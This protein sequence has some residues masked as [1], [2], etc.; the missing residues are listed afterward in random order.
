MKK[1]ILI[2]LVIALLVGSCGQKAKQQTAETV[3][4]SDIRPGEK[5]QFGKVYT[6]VFEYAGCD[7]AND[8]IYKFKKDNREFRIIS[9][10]ILETLFILIGDE[11]EVQWKMDNVW[12]GEETTGIRESAVSIKKIRD[13]K[14]NFNPVHLEY[15]QSINGYKV[16]ALFTPEDIIGDN[17]I[18]GKAILTFTG[19][20]KWNKFSITHNYFA[21]SWLNFLDYFESEHKFEAIADAGK[22]NSFARGQSYQL[23]YD[24]P[25]DESDTYIMLYEEL[26]FF[27][28]DVTLSGMQ[29]YLILTNYRQGQRG[30]SSFLVYYPLWHE[31]DESVDCFLFDTPPFNKL[32][33]SSEINKKEKQIIIHNSQG[34]SDSWSDVYVKTGTGSGWEFKKR[35]NE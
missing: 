12:I 17:K 8:Y 32:D 10:V 5:I 26:P 15:I 1:T 13:G 6:D 3:Y 14:S 4:S 2:L 18:I 31:G 11:V 35:I 25:E 16:E 33:W 7:V 23:N 34:A 30:G 28:A 21:V 9:S 24:F 27:F 19:K 29:D 22:L 20:E